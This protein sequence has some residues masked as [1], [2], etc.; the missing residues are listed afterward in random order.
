MRQFVVSTGELILRFR[1]HASRLYDVAFSPEL[2]L[3]ASCGQ[4]Q[5]LKLWRGD[6]EIDAAR[7]DAWVHGVAFGPGGRLV[8]T[9][10]ADLTVNVFHVT[11]GGSFGFRSELKRHEGAVTCLAFAPAEAGGGLASGSVDGTIALWRRVHEDT[12]ATDSDA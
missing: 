9:A 1:A 2:N 4:D 6:V 7:H 11:E 5:L 8:A 3:L 12:D 10:G